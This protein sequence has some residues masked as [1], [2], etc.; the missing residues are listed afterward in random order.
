VN[1]RVLGAVVCA[2]IFNQSLRAFS[3]GPPANRNGVGGVF[4]TAC[5]RTFDLNSGQGSVRILGLPAAWLPGESY[6]LQVVVSDPSAIR[7]GFEFS[8]TGGSGD[9]AGELVPGAD[10]RTRV[11]NGDVNGK[12]VQFIEHTSVGSTIGSSNVFQFTYR[13]PS[14]ASF[15][16]IRIN[17]AGN[18]ANGNGANT[19]DNIYATE[20]SLPVPA[21]S[22]ERQLVLATRGLSSLSTLGSQTAV[23]AGYARIVN[24]S[25]AAT[26]GLAFISYRQNNAL[27]NESGFPASTPIRSGTMYVEVGGVLNTALGL[28][29]TNSQAATV[30]VYFTDD[31]GSSFGQSSITI[32]ANSQ[33]AA[34]LDQ[35]PF[36]SSNLFSKPISAARTFTFTSSLPV[37]AL[38][39]RTRF[40]ER[41]EFMLT[42]LPVAGTSGSLAVSV[43][44]FG[45][46]AGVTT[47]VL[48]VNGSDATETGTLQFISG[49]GQN[50]NVTIDSQTNSKFT[51]SIPAR[52]S[53]R[54]K[55]A[56]SSNPLAFGWIEVSPSGNSQVPSVAAVLTERI[57][58]V[59]VR[60]TAMGGSPATNATRLYA[61]LSGNFAGREPRSIQTG[62]ALSN[63][64]AASVT[65]TIE[66]TNLDGTTGGTTTL[67][68][69]ARGQIA[70]FLGDIPGLK[71]PT[72]FTGTL[73]IS[74]PAGSSVAVTGF[75]ARYNDRQT[76]ELLV[77]AFPAFD[78]AAPA[79][80]E[81]VFPE[82]VD[83]GGYSTYLVLIG[84]R[85]GPSS[86]SLQFVSSDG[87]PLRLL[88]R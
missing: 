44:L 39:F 36:F 80:S 37:S 29:N 8:A 21:A 73:W 83:S 17:L 64:A 33:V 47:D 1:L 75:R 71:L 57:N 87:Q 62:I 20:L 66:A 55:T 43:P 61:E 2:L 27:L 19:G 56:G 82:L 53:R 40:N 58:N 72:L 28:V 79:A 86:G 32:P 38:T 41:G 23:N 49:S 85:G 54:F 42:A 15:G 77:T 45:D 63:S 60:E 59:T 13:T 9:Q 88:M 30:S 31:D 46:G 11:I 6:T 81:L 14:D 4:C 24:A 35:T 16:S 51:Y 69:P 26:A 25:P 50:M 52:S 74:A 3:T 68:V 12:T 18:A 34:F 84:A 22:S 65:I 70:L 10:G 67:S 76:P 5:H 7:F 48:L 78:E